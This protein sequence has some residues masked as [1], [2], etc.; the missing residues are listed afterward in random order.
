MNMAVYVAKLLKWLSRIC[1]LSL[2]VC[3]FVCLFLLVLFRLQPKK[4][5]LATYIYVAFA[6]H[7]RVKLHATRTTL[8]A[9]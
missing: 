2:C 5:R 9:Y 1:L 7:S 6:N 4:R 3:V 8:V